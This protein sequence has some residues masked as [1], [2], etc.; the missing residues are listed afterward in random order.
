MVKDVIIQSEYIKLGQF[1][2]YNAIIDNGSYAK[3]FLLENNVLVNGE[4]EECRG[5]KLYRGDIIRVLDEEFLI[6]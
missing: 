1:L 6:K 5:R 3:I 4:K 2:K